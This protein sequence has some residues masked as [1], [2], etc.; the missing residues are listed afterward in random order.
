MINQKKSFIKDLEKYAVEVEI[1][2]GWVNY[3][4]VK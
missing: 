3:K 4:N 1:A 2:S